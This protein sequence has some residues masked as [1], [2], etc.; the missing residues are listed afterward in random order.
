MVISEGCNA[1]HF[2]FT[3]INGISACVLVNLVAML[4]N[5]ISLVLRINTCFSRE[6]HDFDIVLILPL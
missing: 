5:I 1:G 3:P 2:C 4:K 6:F